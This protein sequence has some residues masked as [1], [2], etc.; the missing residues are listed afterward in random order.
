[1]E[2]EE[3]VRYALGQYASYATSSFTTKS[4]IFHAVIDHQTELCYLMWIE[5]SFQPKRLGECV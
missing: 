5:S 3:K 1:M 2:R 4:H